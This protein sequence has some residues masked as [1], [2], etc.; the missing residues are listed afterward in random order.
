[1]SKAHYRKYNDRTL[2]SSKY[3]KKDDVNVRAK[4]KEEARR[5]IEQSDRDIVHPREIEALSDCINVK[6]R[7]K[8]C[9]IAGLRLEEY[10][11]CC[12]KAHDEHGDT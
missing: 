3:H 7:E 1:M 6:H 5:E 10:C 12:R 9:Y 4:L 8:D 11:S 2:C